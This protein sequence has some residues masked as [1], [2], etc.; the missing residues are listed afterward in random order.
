MHYRYIGVENI[1]KKEEQAI[2]PFLTIFSTLC[3]L[4]STLNALYL[5]FVWI[6]TSL[7]LCRLVMG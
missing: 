3:Y 4:F 5:Q 6:P 7:K 2:S 1:V